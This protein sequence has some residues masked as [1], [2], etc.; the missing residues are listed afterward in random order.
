MKVCSKCGE[1]KSA[2]GFYPSS[3]KSGG[4]ESWCKACKNSYHAEWEKT[5]PD[6]ARKVYRTGFLRRTYG[7]TLE[8]YTAMICAQSNQCA[9]CGDVMTTPCI[10]HDHKTGKVRSLLCRGCN[11]GIGGLKEDVN[12]LMRAVAYLEQHNQNKKTNQ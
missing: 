8:N 5:F 4:L 12:I 2:E 6:K 10:D 7:L 11:V 1:Q 3:T 9:I